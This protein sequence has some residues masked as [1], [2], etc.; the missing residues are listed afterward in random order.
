M[1]RDS[2][3]APPDLG[4]ITYEALD[5]DPYPIYQQLRE[6]A[7]IAYIPAF[8]E[9]FVTRWDDCVTITT[10]P[11][12]LAAGRDLDDE[13]FGTPNV[14]TLEGND[15]KSLRA[16]ID[17]TLRPRAVKAYF[18]A[19]ARPVVT[20]YV[21]RL[22]PAGGCD[23]TTDLFERISVRV[24]SNQLGMSDLDDDTL[25]RWFHVL[26][27]GHD[28]RDGAEAAVAAEIDAYMR[29]RIDTLR[30][31]PDDSVLSHMLHGG[32]D[33]GN[34]RDYD[35]VM[36][37]LRVI[38]LGGLQ[39]PGHTVAN[40]FFGLFSKPDQLAAVTADPHTLA[41]P[42]LNEGLR[43]IAPVGAVGRTARTDI[44]IRDV[45][46]PAGGRVTLVVASANRDPDRFD[47]PDQYDLNRMLLP[48]ASFGYGEH[49]CSGHFFAR[50]LGQMVIEET[51]TRLPGL[52]PDPDNEPVV[53]GYG[54]RAAKNLPARW[55]H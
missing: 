1:P 53:S 24:V 45:T 32:R 6:H 42:A 3:V 22:R 15:H 10:T 36:P 13:F 20:D 55:D 44:T 38:I 11:G 14:L 19:A 16:G 21:E 49:Y 48:N 47:S 34:P 29:R 27:A 23:L 33:D 52:R 41:A 4:A 40:A 31:D 51:V 26:S 39:E 12:A 17:T 37:T 30:R 7:P 43:W 50:Q 9:W 46:I 25:V 28:I 5:L 18:E 8:D 54:F 2:P 35:D